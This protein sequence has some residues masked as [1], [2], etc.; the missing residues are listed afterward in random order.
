[1]SMWDK[2]YIDEEVPGYVEFGAE[3]V[4]SFQ[5]GYVQ[6]DVD[7]RATERGDK[8]AVEFSFEG[9]DGADGSPCSGRGW[10][11]LDGEALTGMFYFYRGDESE[12]QL[13]RMPKK[14][15]KRRK[16]K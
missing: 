3:N 2:D 5:F 14:R 13:S 12:I 16:R 9:G 6:A 10:M 15:A 1:M 11:T 4:G 7:Y 8:P